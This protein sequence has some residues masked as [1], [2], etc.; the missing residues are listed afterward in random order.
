MKEMHKKGVKMDNA[1]MTETHKLG[2]TA[3]KVLDLLE[4]RPS[5]GLK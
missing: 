4:K 1:M 3:A 2:D 5:A